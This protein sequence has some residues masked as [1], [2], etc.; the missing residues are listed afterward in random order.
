MQKHTNTNHQTFLE[1]PAH[2][3]LRVLLLLWLLVGFVACQNNQR[4][5]HVANYAP[6][7]PE[8][9]PQTTP[10]G[11]VKVSQQ[12]KPAPAPP[13]A[14][15]PDAPTIT[16]K[17]AILI[18]RR[19]RIL[20]EKNSSQ[21]LPTA[22][23]QKLLLGI[24]IA[25]AGR[26]D[27]YITVS[28]SDTACEPT[29]I[30]LQAGHAY[31][32]ADLLKAVLVRSSNDIA[33]CLARDH[34]G[35]V[36]AFAAAMNYKA[37]QLGMH[38]SYFTNASGLPTPSGQYSTARDLAILARAAMT[39][40]VIRDA[41]NTEAMTFYF[42]NGNTK[43]IH[44]TNEVLKTN[45]NCIG[46]K[47]GYTRAAGRCLVSAASDGQNT[48]IAVILGSQLPTVW[49]ESDALLKYGLAY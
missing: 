33:R 41:V 16:A 21:R 23:T 12:Q 14:N 3:W 35:S 11:P 36:T 29:K 10:P 9:G 5:Q 6:T 48:V 32:K 13:L 31:R 40:Q 7:K 27:Q 18:D 15:K 2:Q 17:A 39:R 46:C 8:S 38:N 47:T 49:K 20:F 22:S 25:D 24:L 44:N 45:P 4:R 43:T 42:A 37:R 19:G 26:L 28:A 1:N 34:S 30:G